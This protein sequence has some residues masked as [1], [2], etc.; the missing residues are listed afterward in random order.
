MIRR[1]CFL[2]DVSVRQI[3]RDFTGRVVPLWT[4]QLS[5]CVLSFEAVFDGF[6]HQSKPLMI[7]KEESS[8]QCALEK[9]WRKQNVSRIETDLFGSKQFFLQ[10]STTGTSRTARL[11]SRAFL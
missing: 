6:F 2:I 4:D 8:E 7:K 1:I 9:A 11:S 3:S 5:K 10:I